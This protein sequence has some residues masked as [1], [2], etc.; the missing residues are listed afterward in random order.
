MTCSLEAPWERGRSHHSDGPL[1]GRL[2]P[3]HD[4][5]FWAEELSYLER[6]PDPGFPFQWCLLYT[7]NKKNVPPVTVSS[8]TAQVANLLSCKFIHSYI[9]PVIR[10]SNPVSVHATTC[11]YERRWCCPDGS[12][13]ARTQGAGGLADAPGP[14]WYPPKEG[15]HDGSGTPIPGRGWQ[16]G[17][18]RGFLSG[19]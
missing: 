2:R 5:S 6:D 4:V 11:R 3:C 1:Q 16:P 19:P 9:H 13:M 7:E 8:L 17:G 12:A 10:A 15:G 14:E 18:L